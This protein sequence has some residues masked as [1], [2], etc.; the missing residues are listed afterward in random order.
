MSGLRAIKYFVFNK[1]T[2]EDRTNMSRLPVFNDQSR[3]RPSKPET[4][5]L[6]YY[7]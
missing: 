1:P 3:P 5:R 2:P 4:D 6:G 7:G